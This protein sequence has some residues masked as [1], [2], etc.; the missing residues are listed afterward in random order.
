MYAW[1]HKCVTCCPGFA[2]H[3]IEELPEV[4]LVVSDKVEEL[5]RTKEAVALLK[6]LRAWRDIEK[7]RLNSYYLITCQCQYINLG[8]R[9]AQRVQH[10]TC[11]QEVAV[12]I[13]PSRSG[14]KI[15]FSIVNFL[16]SLFVNCSIPLLP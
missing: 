11:D 16:C 4:P 15:F 8:V 1:V 7:V 13:P 5:K 9:I 12:L 10:Q 6:K 2:G 14:W 3:R